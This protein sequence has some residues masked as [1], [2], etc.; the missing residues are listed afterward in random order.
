M[1]PSSATLH[2]AYQL[3]FRHYGHQHWWPGETPLEVCV[4]A[5]LTQNTNWGNVEKAISQIK[6]AGVMDPASMYGLKEAKL[7]ELIRPAGYYNVKARRLHAFLKVVVVSFGGSLE[8]M[9]AQPVHV[10]RSQLLAI[11]GIGPETADSMV[12]YAAGKASFVIDAYTR[13][14]F[15]RHGWCVP[16]VEYHD[17]Q[18]LC[19]ILLEKDGRALEHSLESGRGEAD[20]GRR[21]VKPDLVDYWQD[22]HAQ[23]VNIGKDF[24][25]P[26]SPRCAECPLKPLL[27]DGCV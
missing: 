8:S 20:P 27:P 21:P 6:Q 1:K 25:R 23:L 5:I 14:I 10:L 19:M 11:H 26:K 16:D 13:R 24:C 4:G 15:A 22:Y 18:K 2:R 17:L 7:A 3:L 9:F 12:L